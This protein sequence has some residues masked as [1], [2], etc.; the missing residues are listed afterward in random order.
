MHVIP[1]VLMAGGF[2]DIFF[3]ECNLSVTSFFFP[4]FCFKI[5]P[6]DFGLSADFGSPAAD[7]PSL[8]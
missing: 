4:S 6:D 5:F 8:M 2:L 1:A 7:M 3:V